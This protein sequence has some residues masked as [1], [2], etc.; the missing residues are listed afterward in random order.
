MTDTAPRHTP[1]EDAQGLLVS[2]IG[3]AFGIVLL[4]TAGLVTGG[5]AGLALLIS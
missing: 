5:T 1:L 2:I 3:G 4:R